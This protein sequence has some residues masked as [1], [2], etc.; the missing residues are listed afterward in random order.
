MMFSHLF[1]VISML[2][3]LVAVSTTSPAD[4]TSSTPTSSTGVGG[5]ADKEVPYDRRHEVPAAHVS[6]LL[7]TPSNPG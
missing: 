7:L 1:T 4:D 5:L 3:T 6:R 2:A